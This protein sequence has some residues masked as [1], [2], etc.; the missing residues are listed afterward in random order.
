MTE[1]VVCNEAMMWCGLVVVTAA[2]CLL[3]PHVDASANRIRTRRELS[4]VA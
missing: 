4:R 2:V 1:C 3:Y